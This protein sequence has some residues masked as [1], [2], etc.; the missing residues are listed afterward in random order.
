MGESTWNY[1]RKSHTILRTLWIAVI[2]FLLAKLVAQLIWDYR[3]PLWLDLTGWI[4]LIIIWPSRRNLHETLAFG[5]GRAR[6]G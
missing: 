5:A 1:V 6:C 4:A 3:A 2:V